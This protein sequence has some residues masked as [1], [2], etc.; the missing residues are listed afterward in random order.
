MVSTKPTSFL[1]WKYVNL[2]TFKR[3]ENTMTP[4]MEDYDLG[5]G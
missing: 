3:E 4:K 5:F 1:E 2:N